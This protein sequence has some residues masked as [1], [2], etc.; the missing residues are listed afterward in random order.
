MRQPWREFPPTRSWLT[1]PFI[2]HP[3]AQRALRSRRRKRA[4]PWVTTVR[5]LR[6]VRA[7]RSRSISKLFHP[8]PRPNWLREKTRH[9]DSILRSRRSAVVLRAR[10]RSRTMRAMP[11]LICSM[12]F[13]TFSEDAGPA[14]SAGLRRNRYPSRKNLSFRSTRG[15]KQRSTLS[16]STPAASIS[17]IAKTSASRRKTSRSGFQRRAR[18][19]A[20][21]K[22]PRRGA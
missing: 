9:T 5:K 2:F 6:W 16:S 20:S 12:E 15:A 11:P 21:Q 10:L 17:W 1:R 7:N 13:L 8:C 18:P 3:K 14:S 4:L 19:T 22:W